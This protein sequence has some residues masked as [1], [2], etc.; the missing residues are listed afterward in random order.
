MRINQ[1]FKGLGADG[2]VLPDRQSERALPTF[3]PS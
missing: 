2:L 1:R 3:D